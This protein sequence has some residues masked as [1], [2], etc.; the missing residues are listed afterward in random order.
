MKKSITKGINLKFKLYISY[1]LILI[2]PAIVIGI[3]SFTTAKD[4]VEKELLAGVEE[5]INLLNSS[6][7][8][9]VQT[10]VHDVK[11]LSTSVNWKQEENFAVNNQFSQYKALH[12]EVELVY[13]GTETGLFIQ[14]PDVKMPSDYDPRQ[15]D[16]YKDAMNKKGEAT[17]SQPYISAS[18]NQIVVTVS[19]TLA[20]GSGVVAV[21]LDLTYIQKLADQLQIGSS[22]YVVILDSNNKFIYHPTGEIGSTVDSEY[23]ELYAKESGSIK[24]GLG[25]DLKVM[26]LTTNDLTGWKIAGN[27]YYSDVNTAA[28]P[29]LKMTVIVIIFSIIIG[30]VAV[31]FIVRSVI[32]PINYLKEKAVTISRGDLTERITLKSNDE[33]GALGKAFHEMQAS[34]INLIRS[35]NENAELVAASSEELSASADQTSAATEMVS[36]SIQEVARSAETQTVGVDT[37]AQSLAEI[38]I[39][40]TRIADYSSKVSELSNQATTQAEIGGQAVTKTVMQMESIHTSVNE[41]NEKINSLSERSKEVRSIL[42]VITGIAEQTNLLA[43]NAAIEAARAGEHGKGFAVVADEVRKLAEQSQQSVK[44]IQEIVARIQEDTDSSVQIM[45]LVK[46]DVQTGVQLS[47]DTI[48][49]FNTIIQSMKEITPQMEEVSAT[50]EQVSAAVQETTATTNEVAMIAQ[51]NAATSEEVAASAEEQLASMEEITA[52]AQSLSN[53]AEDLKELISRFKY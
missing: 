44:E 10:K 22:G 6:V 49:K 32:R 38:S 21:D 26:S 47:N 31:V 18:T 15:R 53:M 43:L 28:A 23:E 12:P 24:Y 13:V 45:A 1:L 19:Q 36:S 3:L 37:S 27:F 46:N 4:S 9:L 11:V 50:A 41:S 20:D 40:V 34:L 29:I 14:S 35:V 17:I 7:D 52:S 51:S 16:W 33:I 39:G 8:N 42:E 5:N 48:E 30:L 2:I 25:D